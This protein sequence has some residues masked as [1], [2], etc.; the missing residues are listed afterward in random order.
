MKAL[1]K[2]KA[3]KL[4]KKI[5]LGKFDENDIDSLF[6]RL[7]AYSDDYPV[8]REVADFVAHNDERH[9]GLTNDSLG[10]L[11]L[12]M[13]FF[14][15]YQAHKR[16]LDVTASF[17]LWIKKLFLL[18][19]KK[20]DEDEIKKNLKVSRETLASRIENGFKTDKKTG[21]AVLKQGTKSQQTFE[22]VK[23]IMMTLH[24]GPV[25]TQ[26]M[27]ISDLV[28]VMKKNDI[29]IDSEVFIAQADKVTLCVLLLLHNA[30]FDC[31]DHKPGLAK[32]GCDTKHVLLSEERGNELSETSKPFG[33]LNIEGYVV[34][35]NKG[36]DVTVQSRLIETNLEV[37]SWCSGNMFSIKYHSLEESID[38]YQAVTFADDLYLTEGFLLSNQATA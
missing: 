6:M 3:Q 35:D 19:I 9:K 34:I 10:V 16:K 12:Q 7:R 36:K 13:K 2:N 14:F 18:L 8:F 4:V 1:E 31:T 32:I 24:T 30:R 28:G 20:I 11:Y 25:F 21:T 15:S 29:E 23:F 38:V 17:P 26:D 5:Q 37:R 27:L 22:M 33:N